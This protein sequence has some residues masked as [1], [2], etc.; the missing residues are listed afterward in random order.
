VARRRA[1]VGGIVAL[2]W[3]SLAWG[4][5]EEQEALRRRLAAD[6]VRVRFLSNEEASVLQGLEGLEA[7]IRDKQ[8]Q[9]AALSQEIAALDQR[10]LELTDRI[11]AN[12]AKLGDL[13]ERFGKRAAAMLR[14][15]RARLT[16][17]LRRITDPNEVRRSKDR[18][19][20]VKAYDLALIRGM[21]DAT[22]ADRKLRFELTEKKSAATESRVALDAA[23]AEA[24]DLAAEREALLVAIR[25]ER[26]GAARLAK[27]LK[28]AAHRLD[29]YMGRVLGSG[30][31]PEPV[32]GGFA[33]QR[34]RLPWPVV[35]RLEVPFGKKVDPLSDMVL[36]QKGI[37]IRAA[38]SS[39]VR[40]VFEGK[41]AFIGSREGYGNLLVLD[42]GGY[43][44]LYAH[45]ES[46]LVQP[47]QAVLPQ[48]VV[49]YVGDSGSTKG[50]YLYFE[51][52]SGR[53]PVDPIL[54]L[55]P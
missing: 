37:D 49:G 30:P 52:R 31:Q 36:L 3:A 21:L 44:S 13:R 6:R 50:A 28:D 46:F 47:G 33:A 32:A 23:V 5:A 41:V 9:S 53:D 55:A 11:V 7:G 14:L 15:R 45:L 39:P 38:Q 25:K 48:Q 42:H 19:D 20:F 40:A 12:Q 8:R 22:A 24:L 10:V 27:E 51:L 2:L 1:V 35:G 16:R 29:A 54:W 18:F 34:G 17:L 26:V 43:Y 4:Q